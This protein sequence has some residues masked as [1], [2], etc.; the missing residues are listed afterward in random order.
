MR[1]AVKKRQHLSKNANWE[2]TGFHV[3]AE[4]AVLQI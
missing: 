3:F 2:Q 1:K 4:L